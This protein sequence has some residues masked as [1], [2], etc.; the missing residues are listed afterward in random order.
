MVDIHS[1]LSLAT[2]SLKKNNIDTPRLDAEVILSNVLKRDRVYLIAHSDY[3]LSE[4]EYKIFK[5]GIGKRIDGMPVAYIVGSKEFMSLNFETPIGVLIPRP[6]TEIL[7][8]NAISDCKKYDGNINIADVCCGS[9]AIGISIAKYI[10]N[11]YLTLIDISPTAYQTSIK[12]AKLNNVEDRVKVFLGDILYPV[13]DQKFDMIVS[14]PPYI[15]TKIIDS[16]QR[17]VK[18]YEPSIALDG[19]EDGLDFYSKITK[20]AAVCLKDGGKL[21]F[22]TGYNQAENVTRIMAESNFKYIKVYKDLG[23]NNRCIAGIK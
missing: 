19:G 20:Q 4:K 3:I 8:E 23:G 21:Y 1:A 10:K 6:D 11:S 18:D 13:L 9:G 16:L 12:N 22:E 5:D 15:E 7:V 17:E 14:N 2:C